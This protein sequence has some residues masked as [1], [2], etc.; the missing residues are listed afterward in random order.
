MFCFFFFFPLPNHM[1]TC[2]PITRLIP[3][4]H[5]TEY[6]HETIPSSFFND[7]T[8][9]HYRNQWYVEYKK[10]IQFPRGRKFNLTTSTAILRTTYW[11]K[12][13]LTCRMHLKVNTMEKKTNKFVLFTRRL[14]NVSP[15]F[16]RISKHPLLGC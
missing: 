5:T 13:D 2:C 15:P 3:Y 7:K 11:G 8:V 4:T 16:S 10:P 9:I 12:P 14:M 1:I 6:S